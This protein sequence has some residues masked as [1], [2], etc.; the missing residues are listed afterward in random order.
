MCVCVCIL[1]F[2]LDEMIIWPD[3]ASI[4]VIIRRRGGGQA[5]VIDHCAPRII[6]KLCIIIYHSTEGLP[7]FQ[8]RSILEPLSL[9][10]TDLLGN[11]IN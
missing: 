11:R 8:F 9:P 10:N 2:R 1:R 6:L 3:V 4:T 7:P 5:H